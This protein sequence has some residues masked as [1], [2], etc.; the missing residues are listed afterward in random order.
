M[1]LPALMGGT[2]RRHGLPQS[3]EEIVAAIEHL[4]ESRKEWLRRLIIDG[5]RV[6][7]LSK[8]I[9]GYKVEPRVHLRIIRH[10][11]KSKVSLVLMPRGAGKTLIGTVAC[12]IHDLIKN[13]NAKILIVSKKGE[14]AEAML[15]QVKTHLEGNDKLIALFGEFRPPKNSDFAWSTKE[16]EVKGIT[17]V[18][19]RI[20]PSVMAI[21]IGGALPSKHFDK[22]YADDL[23]DIENSKTSVQRENTW[24]WLTHVM[25]PTLNPETAEN[26][27]A[28]QI[29]YLGTKYHDSDTYARLQEK[30]CKDTTLIIPA[31]G[32]HDP[33]DPNPEQSFWPE[34][35]S[36]ETLLDM[37]ETMGTIAFGAQMQQSTEAMKG[38]IFRY[39]QCIDSDEKDVPEKHI[40]I[41]AVDLASKQ[42]T[43]ADRFAIVVIKVTLEKEPR[44]FVVYSF[45][46]RISVQQQAKKIVDVAAEYKPIRVGIEANGYQLTQVS[47]SKEEAKKRNL[48]LNI[49]PIFTHKDKEIRAHNLSPLFEQERVLFFPGQEKLKEEIVLMPDG[50]HDDGFDALD[51]AISLA[52]RRGNKEKKKRR[53]TE[54]DFS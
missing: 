17:N 28:G 7:I 11:F 36:V 51:L 23:V 33:N 43:D 47:L 4:T 42:A 1:P 10:H 35:F 39:A 46:S 49:I 48:S 5:N 40:T 19:D 15:G 16:I 8:Y 25:L 22:I 14:N 29:R 21:G 50:D 13:R 2:N 44:F 45:I 31:L 30:S 53:E 54:P 32:Q 41:M 9:L 37:R 6:D 12:V 27:N 38:K 52:V 3:R 34:K 24:N 26:P 18:G 20:T